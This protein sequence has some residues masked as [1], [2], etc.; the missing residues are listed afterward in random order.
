MN[1]ALEAVKHS[2]GNPQPNFDD[3]VMVPTWGRAFNDGNN[4]KCV[5]LAR[6][7]DLYLSV[8]KPAN[9]AYHKACCSFL[10]RNIKA[11]STA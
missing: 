2:P 10:H 8:S 7:D 1:T 3:T 4:E 11:E 9:E 6:I 5:I